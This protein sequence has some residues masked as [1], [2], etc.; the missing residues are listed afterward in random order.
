MK[1]KIMRRIALPLAA[2][3]VSGVYMAL[4]PAIA[5]AESKT[6][7]KR[8]D[9]AAIQTVTR[10]ITIDCGS[11]HSVAIKP[12]GSLWAWGNNNNGEL[13]DGTTTERLTPIKIMD[14]VA[15][16]SAGNQN[17]MAVRTDG[18]LWVWG[19]NFFGILGDGTY[20]DRLTP[21][22]LMDG[23]VASV[24]CG[25]TNAAVKTDGSLWAWGQSVYA[26][27]IDN[28]NEVNYIPAKIMDDVADAAIG[29]HHV[30]AVK[31]DGSLWV[32]GENPKGQLGDGTVTTFDGA[33]NII[34]DNGK[35]RPFKLM[36]NVVAV[37]AGDNHSLALKT[38]GSV[39]AWGENRYG[40]LGDG[41]NNDRLAPVYVTDGAVAISSRGNLSAA[42][43]ADG[44][45]WCW[46][47][48]T[49]GQLGDGTGVERNAPV[50]IMDNVLEVSLGLVHSLAAKAD[51]SLWAWGTNTFGQIGD[52]TKDNRPIPV[53]VM[54]D[55]KLPIGVTVPVLGVRII[56]NG[57]DLAFDVPP[58]IED[59]RT[60]VP[61]RVIFEALG[62]N[63]EWDNDTKTVTAVKGR[64]KVVMQVGDA[65]IKINKKIVK[66]DAPP[67]IKDGRALVPARAVAEAFDAAVNW[68]GIYQIVT[69]DT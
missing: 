2:I 50:K 48:N 30:M 53:K 17:T 15:V 58:V 42:V 4:P 44:S 49:V 41:T 11:A 33:L 62:A 51:G 7:Q 27:A 37:A 5:A 24:F 20:Q 60:L 68:D 25:T 8:A 28:P 21:I 46:G 16:V 18:S 31:R 6:T 40:Q 10:K 52:G 56:V 3:I 26:H 23:G 63:I 65:Y 29:L 38:D 14:K 69:I 32:W 64:T 67:V 19:S 43:K 61:V 55:V 1:T 35:S 45:L 39:W 12:D 13:G 59:G 66:L 34:S 54:D 57:R 36:D 9:S 22:K 47:W